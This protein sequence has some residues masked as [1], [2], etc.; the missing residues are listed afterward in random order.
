M[1]EV[2]DYLTDEIIALC[3]RKDDAVAM[4]LSE[5]KKKLYINFSG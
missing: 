4:I 5:H 3:S 2:R 1:Y